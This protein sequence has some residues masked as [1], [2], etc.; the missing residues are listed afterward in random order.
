MIGPRAVLLA[1]S[2]AMLSQAVLAQAP[3][4]VASSVRVGD[5]WTYDRK[6]EITGAYKDTYT[7][8]VTEVSPQEVVTSAA[9]QGKSE[10]TVTAY[11][12][13]WNV[14]TNGVWKYKP[15]A[16]VGLRPPLAVGKEWRSEYIQSHIVTNARLKV[17]SISKITG[18]ET[19]TVPAGTYA[20]FKVERQTRA[21]NV[22]APAVVAEYQSVM[23]Y[24]PEINHWVRRM[25]LAKLNKRTVSN[26]S[27]ELTAF[28]RKEP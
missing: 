3:A 23:W 19:I 9:L 24:A 12:P 7:E 8:T 16:G 26:V 18:Q 1:A 2:V 28:A 17:L 14:I 21:T 5:H 25:T 22:A 6:N 4:E 27:E 20:A 13:D 11:D 10:S 15:T